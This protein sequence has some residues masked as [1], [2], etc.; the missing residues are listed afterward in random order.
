MEGFPFIFMHVLV[1]CILVGAAK[2]L[3]CSFI[4]L[5]FLVT[6]QVLLFRP[7][8]FHHPSLCQTVTLQMFSARLSQV[9]TEIIDDIDVILFSLSSGC[10]NITDDV[11]LGVSPGSVRLW[12][13]AGH[14]RP[15]LQPRKSGQ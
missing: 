11:K 6:L 2:F 8:H 15:R 4:F 5:H 7:N 14:R 10:R 13:K 1:C 9:G 12:G 3:L